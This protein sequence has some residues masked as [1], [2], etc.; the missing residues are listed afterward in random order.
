MFPS[1]LGG[2]LRYVGQRYNKPETWVTEFGTGITDENKWTGNAALKDTYRTAFYSQYLA[3][4]C[5]AIIDSGLNVPVIFAWSLW[6][7]FE[8]WVA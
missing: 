7:N 4:A 6:D 3:E 2:I 8:W 5:K 1:S